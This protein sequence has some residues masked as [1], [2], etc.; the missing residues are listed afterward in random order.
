[1]GAYLKRALRQAPAVLGLLLLVGAIYVVQREFRHLKVADIKK[2]LEAIPH[3]ALVISFLW[4]L[5]AYFILTFYDRLGTIYAGRK[6]SYGRVSFASFCAYALAHNLGFA[7]VSGAAVRYRLYAHWGLSPLQ[8]GKVIAFC[9]LTF[10]L[11]AMVLGGVILFIEPQAVPFFGDYIPHWGMYAIAT[12]LWAIVGAYVTLSRVLG[13]FRMFGHEIVL[14]SWRMAILQV[15][16]AT[17]DVA[18]TAAIFYALLPEVPGLTYVRFLGVYLA[19]YSAGLAANLPGGIGVFDTAMLLGLESYLSPPEIVGAIVVFRLYYYI[20]PLFLAGSLFA[21]NEILL[22]GWSLLGRRGMVGEASTRLRGAQA[23][24]S[25]SQPDFVA[26][27]CTGAVLLCG[28]LLL[29]LGVLQSGSDLSWIDPDFSE[30]MSGASEY[31]PSLIG[32]AL[33]VLATA[34]A[35]RVSLAWTLSLVLLIVA[36]MW[37][38]I[39]G[40]PLWIPLL[41]LMAVL[42]LAPFHRTFYRHARLLSGPLQAGTVLPMLTLLGCILALVAFAPRLRWLPDDSWW[43]VI[44]SPDIPNSLRFSVGLAVALALT[45]IWRLIR[46]GRVTYSPW[47]AET[48]ARFVLAGGRTAM[49]ADGVVWGEADRA[50]IAFRRVGRVMLGMGDPVGPASDLPSAVW[51]LRDLA[52]QERMDPAIW[53]A[54]RASLD[55]YADLGLAAL[56]LGQDGLPLGDADDAPGPH[57]THYLVCRAERDLPA[58]LPLLPKLALTA[59]PAGDDEELAR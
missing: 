50:G 11:G 1:V 41:L 53:R 32:A 30:L 38:A 33:M 13:K 36:A 46:P 3:T 20:I 9:S 58:L 2:A 8:I 18:A 6:V 37:T 59:P 7:A 26:A 28:A 55:V 10:G 35:Q 51:R 54:G 29:S 5:V 48:R 16:L 40:E 22:R 45:A 4:T 12:V 56:P 14:P 19:S 44:I 23:I 47:D 57:A 49:P 39:Q 31:L 52:R 24:G 25:W 42:S 15:L 27:A 21:G 43:S 17:A 34:L